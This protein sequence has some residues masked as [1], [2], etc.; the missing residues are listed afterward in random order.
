MAD[1]GKESTCHRDW[2]TSREG[3]SVSDPYSLDTSILGSIPIRIRIQVLMTKNWKKFTVKKQNLFIFWSKT[4]I[5]QS[6]GLRIRNTG[7]QVREPLLLCHL[8]SVQWIKPIP[9]TMTKRVVFFTHLVLWCDVISNLDSCACCAD[10]T[11]KKHRTFP[12]TKWNNNWCFK[13][14]KKLIGTGTP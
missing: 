14:L 9:T 4:T 6:L 8:M 12:G 11:A 1:A 7:R 5:Y 2:R 13:I 3:S 10:C